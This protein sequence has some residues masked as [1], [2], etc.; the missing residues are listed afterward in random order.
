MT[1][2]ARLQTVLSHSILLL[3]SI[4]YTVA[5]L[6][7]PDLTNVKK[8]MEAIEASAGMKEL[9]VSFGEQR[10]QRGQYL[11]RKGIPSSVSH[12]SE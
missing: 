3:L 5:F 9:V 12:T 7:M 6:K 2:P 11:P 10:V 4:F 1:A 8:F